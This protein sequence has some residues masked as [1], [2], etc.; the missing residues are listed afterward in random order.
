MPY[1]IEIRGIV[2][3]VGF[4]P[5]V[6]RAA[7][8]LGL[9]GYVRNCGSYV[10]VVVDSRPEELIEKLIKNLPPVAK[11]EDYFI[12]EIDEDLPEDFIIMES[13]DAE[14][15]SLIPPDTAICEDC[16]RELFDEKNRRY[17]YPF[18]NCTNC[19]ARFSVIFALPYDRKYT[20]MKDFKMCKDCLKEYSNPLDRRFHAQTISCKK[21]GPEL[22]LYDSSGNVID[23]DNPIKK[24]AELI[25]DGN[26]G[27]MKSWGG[28]HVVG[29]LEVTD[30]IRKRFRRPQKPFAV[31]VRDL[32]TARK[33]AYINNYEEKVL[34][35]PQRPIVLLRKRIDYWNIAPSLPTIGIYLP[36]SAI[37][38]IFFKYLKHDAVIM[39]SANMPGMPMVVENEKAFKLPVD[40]LLLHNRKIA[41][42]VDDSVI[43]IWRGK[44]LF[45]RKSRGFA[46]YQIKVPFKESIVAL[47]AE[48]NSSVAITYRGKMYLSQLISDISTLEGLN[49]LKE[50][51]D[52]FL[53]MLKVY[54]IDAIS[55]DRNPAYTYRKY[56]HELAEQMGCDVL[57]VQH[58]HAHALSLMFEKNMD[59]IY[60]LTFDGTGYGGI[61][62]GIVE[63]WGGEFLYSTESSFE[64]IASLEPVPLIGGDLAVI[65]PSRILFAIKEIAG[66]D[67]KIYDEK[68]EDLLRKAMKNTR[69][70]TTS[71]GRFLDVLAVYFNIG[72]RRT[73][74]G[75]LAMKLES[76]L[77]KG[78][79][80]YDFELDVYNL[81]ERKVVSIKSL[82]EDIFDLNGK[83]E[84]I[85]YSAVYS[86][87]KKFVEIAMDVGCDKLG[88]TGGV[89][90]NWVIND[91][92][93]EI[94]EREGIE[95]LVH[96]EFAPGDNGIAVGQIISAHTNIQKSS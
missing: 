1:K 53:K 72:N 26:I 75:E 55:I 6:Y 66:S 42:R 84:D 7:K 20:T 29:I 11:I 96:E 17:M 46:P 51:V 71:F 59:E 58:H 9:R 40:Y 70:Y 87:L 48:E 30:E 18:I 34:L 68:K 12:S 5:T 23:K 32:K 39:T 78:K 80:K 21:C 60:A 85:A 50:V 64:R 13:K 62:D 88:F 37:H 49:S 27:L 35:S 57:E 2:Q 10:E 28:M 61:Y 16:L 63:S 91:M 44:T 79:R 19:G 86:V 38:H 43:K 92:L 52:N 90:Y 67:L 69:V 73:Y 47:G 77:L 25:D 4:R 89:A 93:K 24:F 81:R 83:N 54:R 36:Y 45:I 3:G 76:L 95:F 14:R 22:K 41:N 56:S 15:F 8:S 65:E 74:E 31:M 33:Y 82:F 94:T